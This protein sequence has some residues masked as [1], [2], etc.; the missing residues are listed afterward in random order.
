MLNT[1]I[2]KLSTAFGVKFFGELTNFIGLKV[3]Q[4][5]LGILA[6][7]SEDARTSSCTE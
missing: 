4:D 7:K 2:N 5:H 1:L 6:E 3:Q